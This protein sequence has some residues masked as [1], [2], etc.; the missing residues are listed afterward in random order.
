MSD[1]NEGRAACGGASLLIW[2]DPFRRYPD[3][4]RPVAHFERAG[5]PVARPFRAARDRA[6]DRAGVAAGALFKPSGSG[7]HT[8]MRP[9]LQAIGGRLLQ[10]VADGAEGAAELRA[11]GGGGADDGDAD[12]S[13]DQAVFN[14]RRAGLVSEKAR[15]EILLRHV[16]N[17][18]LKIERPL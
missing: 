1:K 5:E 14:G 16:I 13:R 6:I 9:G 8:P 12:Q 18:Q 15:D 4:P 11:H 3:L 7:A 10:L 17:L 2:R